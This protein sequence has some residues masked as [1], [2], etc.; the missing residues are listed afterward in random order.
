[1]SSIFTLFGIICVICKVVTLFVD[2]DNMYIDNN[3]NATLILAPV[4][5]SCDVN[6]GP[7]MEL[8]TAPGDWMSL[9][10]EITFTCSF[11]RITEYEFYSQSI[12]TVYIGVWR[13]MDDNDR[14]K[15]IGFNRIDTN[16]TGEQVT[17]N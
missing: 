3:E 5:P 1:M 13:T 11:S 9:F 15:L 10:T 14:F 17:T 8:N 12:D 4:L 16:G 6:G 7:I 2:I